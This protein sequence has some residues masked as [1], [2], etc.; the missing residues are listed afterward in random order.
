MPRLEFTGTL[1]ESDGGGGRWIEVPFDVKAAFGQ[2]RPPVRGTVNGTPLRSRLSV[3]GGRS[4]LGL[5]SD[6][7]QWVARWGRRP[8]A[9]RRSGRKWESP[10]NAGLSIRLDC[11]GS[12]CE[13]KR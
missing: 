2:A 13:R 7:D 10:A 6:I 9:A 12:G 1:N 3:Y 4:Y 11:Q 8:R 5:R